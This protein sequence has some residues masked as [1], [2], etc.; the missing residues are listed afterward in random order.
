MRNISAWSIRNPVPSLVL[1]AALTLAGIIAFMRMD[2]NN[3]PDISFPGV[4]VDVSQPGA[5]PTELET[6]V[7]QRVEAAVRGISGVDE[8]ELD[9]HRGR[10]QHLRTVLD[11]HAGRPRRQRR[12]RG[13]VA[14]PLQPARGHSRA[15]D[16]PRRHRRRSDRLHVG[17]IDRHDARTAQLV[18][19][20]HDRAAPALDLRHG[21]GGAHRRRRPR[22]SRRARSRQDAGAGHHREPGQRPADR[23]ERQRRR[24]PCRDR[25]GRT[26]GSRARQRQGR[27][28][29]QPEADPAFGRP[30][31]QA[32]RH[33]RREGQLRRAAQPG[34]DERPPG[35][36]LRPSEGQGLFG[37]HRLRRGDE[38]AA[39]DR[40]GQPQ[41][42]FHSALCLGRLYQ[43]A[44]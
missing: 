6:Q 2:V 9:R 7:T 23:D 29:A 30:H 41:G 5:A 37:R 22:D 12:A 11:R 17:G 14:H 39:A 34:Q 15:A 43:D 27:V 20:Q 25:G 44:V 26:V 8:I 16:Q 31:N 10:Q 4:T 13:G 42:P 40:E 21:G 28:R 32:R 24:R 18:C 36:R 3:N 35:A 33:R 38:G 1:F 19:R